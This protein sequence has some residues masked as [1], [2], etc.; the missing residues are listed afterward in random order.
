MN[1]PFQR[2]GGS[3]TPPATLTYAERAA[4]RAQANPNL[5]ALTARGLGDAVEHL[6]KPIAKALN[7]PCNDAAGGLKPESR[8]AKLRDA[9]NRAVPLG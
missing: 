7:W 2:G 5:A 6:V 4:Q 3:T 1:P 9:L 8:C